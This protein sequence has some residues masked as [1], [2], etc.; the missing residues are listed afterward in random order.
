MLELGP[1]IMYF[2]NK[3]RTIS[4]S[5]VYNLYAVG[6][7]TLANG[8]NQDATGTSFLINLSYQLPISKKVYLGASYNYHQVGL[9]KVVQSTTESSTS[10]TYTYMYPG[11]EFSIRF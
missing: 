10:D 2:I 6:S 5:F 1:R 11:L 9:A 7:R 4:L 8:T 3:S